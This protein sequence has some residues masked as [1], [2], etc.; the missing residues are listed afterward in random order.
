MNFTIDE[1]TSIRRE[2]A[3][4]YTTPSM[5]ETGYLGHIHY[6]DEE[7]VGYYIHRSAQ[8]W[9]RIPDFMD[10]LYEEI[11]TLRQIQYQEELLYGS[12]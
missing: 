12:K 7:P 9:I 10:K 4:V 2:M 8:F 1:H 6:I 11:Y 5:K 3:A